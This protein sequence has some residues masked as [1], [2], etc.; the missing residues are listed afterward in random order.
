[1]SLRKGDEVSTDT[2]ILG[3]EV[4]Y[5]SRNH[6]FSLFG[7]VTNHASLD[8]VQRY[9]TEWKK[10]QLA[11]LTYELRSLDSIKLGTYGV[12]FQP[13]DAEAYSAIGHTSMA[14]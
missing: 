6:G 10:D 7:G 5:S 3:S 2:S 13:E 8:P 4:V 11:G 12:F 9:N 14:G 1:M